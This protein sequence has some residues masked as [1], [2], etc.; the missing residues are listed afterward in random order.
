M[1]TILNRILPYDMSYYIIDIL[2]QKNI[3][4]KITNN[5][6]ICEL[7]MENFIN[8]YKISNNVN[9]IINYDWVNKIK[10]INTFLFYCKNHNYNFND[11]YKLLIKNF[12]KLLKYHLLNQNVLIRLHIE[13]LLDS[14]KVIIN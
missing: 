14:L 2:R 4:I 8:N 6:Y 10:K 7:L 12:I 11:D 5:L 9:F 1:I 3:N 13:R